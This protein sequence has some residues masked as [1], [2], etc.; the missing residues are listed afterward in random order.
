MMR[1]SMV[2]LIAVAVVMEP[3][4]LRNILAVE[5]Y[6]RGIRRG[7]RLRLDEHLLYQLRTG[8]AAVDERLHHVFLWF[9]ARL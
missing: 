1:Q 9:S 2:I 4:M 5:A 3:A 6:P 8:H 7:K